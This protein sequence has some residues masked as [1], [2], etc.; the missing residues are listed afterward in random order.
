MHIGP[1]ELIIVLLLIVLL[2]GAGKVP[3]IGGAL[4]K[5]MKEFRS[6]AREAD[7]GTDTPQPPEEPDVAPAGEPEQA[8]TVPAVDEL[9]AEPTED[10]TS[11][12]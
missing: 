3:E 4:G 1:T 2:F 7:R 12:T 11:T 5:G 8:P 10:E 9:P 6:A